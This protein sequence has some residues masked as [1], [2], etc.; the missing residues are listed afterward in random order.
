[1][2]VRHG[3]HET[4]RVDAACV[5]ESR[6]AVD[7][8]EPSDGSAVLAK[9]VHGPL[10]AI[11]VRRRDERCGRLLHLDDDRKNGKRIGRHPDA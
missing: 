2:D 4:Q 8:G 9:Q 7:E 11:D 6:R 1:V 10:G 5:R 3:R